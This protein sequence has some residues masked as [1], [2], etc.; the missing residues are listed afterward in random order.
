[1]AITRE[2][3]TGR[4]KARLFGTALVLCLMWLSGCSSPANPKVQNKEKQ[5]E[6]QTPM[7]VQNEARSAAQKNDAPYMGVWQVDKLL[8]APVTSLSQEDD[9]NLKGLEIALFSDFADVDGDV[10]D[11]PRYKMESMT[12]QE[13]R[14]NGQIAD[15]WGIKKEDQPVERVQIFQAAN[16]SQ[17]WEWKLAGYSG[18]LYLVDSRMVLYME[19]SYF[20]LHRVTG[21]QGNLVN[22]YLLEESQS[23]AGLKVDK[24]S[25]E[26]TGVSDVTFSGE[27]TVSGSFTWGDAPDYGAQ[28]ACLFTLD[29]ESKKK[30]PVFKHIQN[31]D[32]VVLNGTTALKQG[33]PALEG[34]ATVVISNYS[35][36]EREITMSADVTKVVK[37]AGK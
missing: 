9:D 2:E 30:V 35:I 29:E 32:T 26:G 27:V 14:E 36:G 13:F 20:E 7:T 21:H 28:A 31:E 18:D 24:L 6:V 17:E 37:F 19:G 34:E 10:L 11:T 3:R 8:D 4:F 16:D 1:M 12:L 33:L 15:D 22:K 5:A 23:I 25:R